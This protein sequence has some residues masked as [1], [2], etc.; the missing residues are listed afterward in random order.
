[1]VRLLKVSNI[2][3]YY[4]IHRFKIDNNLY[5]QATLTVAFLCLYAHGCAVLSVYNDLNVRF[6]KGEAM[7]N[8]NITD[9]QKQVLQCAI[10]AK[11]QGKRPFTRGIWRRM[12]D[13]GF[14]VTER[15]CS[16]DLGVLIRTKGSGL[17]SAKFGSRPT[18]WIY[19][20][21]KDE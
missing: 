11:N 8:L 7:E 13:K 21:P 12:K 19:E 1:M 10:D 9:R 2:G 18:V 16:Y 3:C 5:D 14:D 17:F 6:I 4:P 15:Q 20:E